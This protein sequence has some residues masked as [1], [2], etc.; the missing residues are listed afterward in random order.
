MAALLKTK[1]QTIT[2]VVIKDTIIWTAFFQF[3]VSLNDSICAKFANIGY[4]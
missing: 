1:S 3:Y 2:E 4:F